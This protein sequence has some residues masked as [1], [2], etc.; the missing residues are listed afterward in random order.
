MKDVIESGPLNISFVLVGNK[1]DLKD[2]RVISFQSACEFAKQFNLDYIEVSALT[3][4]NIKFVF[5]I[6]AKN[7]A[8]VQDNLEIKELLNRS[9]KSKKSKKKH[10]NN[11]IDYATR[12]PF[13]TETN[14]ICIDKRKDGKSSCCK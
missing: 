7:M 14:S 6:L 4:N 8:F 12:N 2:K 10:R 9:M 1:N 3:G 13:D 5:E 11:Y